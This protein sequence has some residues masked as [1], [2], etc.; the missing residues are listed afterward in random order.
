MPSRAL[1]KILISLL[2]LAGVGTL[3]IVCAASGTTQKIRLGW[4]IPWATQ[5]QLV[6][7]LKKTNI[8]ELCHLDLEFIGFSYGGPLN[9]A[10]LAEEVDILLTADQPALVL[11]SKTD[12]Y[13]IVG[14][15]MYNRVCIYV[16]PQSPITRLGELEG[17]T[18]MGPVGAAAERVA[19]E[20]ISNAGVKLQELRTGNLDMSQQAALLKRSAGP[21]WGAI[22]AMYGFDPLPAVFEESGLARIIHCDKVVSFIVGSK[23]LIQHRRV[24]LVNFLKAFSLSWFYFSQQP[25]AVNQWFAQESRLEVSQKVLDTCAA[26]EPNRNAR[27]LSDLRMTLVPEDFTILENALAFLMNRGIINKPLNIQQIIDLGPLAEAINPSAQREL[28]EKYQ[29]IVEK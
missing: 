1:K 13:A 15:M 12:K 10:A 26:V 3:S 23:H 22:D 18:I 19:L 11:L 2:V 25:H 24:D 8:P 29:K 14:R 4:Q 21:K 16:P 20:A 6:M 28:A 9:K 27:H 7:G 17:K 5:G